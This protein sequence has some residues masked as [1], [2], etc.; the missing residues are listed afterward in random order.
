MSCRAGQDRGGLGLDMPST[1]Q[2]TGYF[3][4]RDDP[5]AGGDLEN[6]QRLSAL[7]WGIGVLLTLFLLATNPPEDPSKAAGWAITFPI[8]LIGLLLFYL[9]RERR[10]T[11]WNLLLTTG[12]AVA[13]CIG[14][15][16]WV[17]GGVGEPYEA[18]LLL[19]VLFVAGTQPPRQIAAFM[20]L[21]FVV[22]FAPLVYDHW[23]SDEAAESAATFVIWCGLAFAGNLL[24]TGVRAQRV[25]LAAEQAEAREEA[26]IDAL[27]G[28][29]NRRAFDE[30]LASEVTRARRL[31]LPLTM[32]MVDI[33]NFKEV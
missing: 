5:Y 14:V 4:R 21:V 13:I 6:A 12:Y 2:L 29:H 17:T 30:I 33:V 18:L 10:I 1:R 8:F 3:A 25:A 11:S 16:Q 19:P 24:M 31:S 7:L 20:V 15:M 23:D 9:N 26:R 27:T 28:L 22:L 32:A